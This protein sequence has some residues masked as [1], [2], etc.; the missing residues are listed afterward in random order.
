MVDTL[1]Y[2][3]LGNRLGDVRTGINRLD[4]YGSTNNRL[5]S[6][7]ENA[8][9]FRSY[10]YDTAGNTLTET[11]PGESFQYSYNNRNHLASV[12]RNAAA[13]ATY[14]YNAFE[15]MTSRVTSSPSK[16]LY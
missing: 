5:I 14:R 12:T 10:T 4:S 15:Q 9:A 13:Y 7:T 8:A 1:D 6:L 11:H 16:R 2:D 3:G